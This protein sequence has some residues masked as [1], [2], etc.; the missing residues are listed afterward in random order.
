MNNMNLADINEY[1][2]NLKLKNGIWF[3]NTNNE[4]FY[5][6]E[7]YD[8]YFQLEEKSFWFIHRNNCIIETIKNFPPSGYI[9]DIGGGNGY[10]SYGLEK[11]AIPTYLVDPGI[12]AIRNAQKRDLKN[13]I[14]SS[15]EDADFHKIGMQEYFLSG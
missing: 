6:T 9:F 12:D 15:F 14:C 2:Y 8:E 5:P 4:I 13:L 1:S 7:A 3:S 11:N 10:V